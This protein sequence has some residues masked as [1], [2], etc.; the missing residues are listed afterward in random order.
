[1]Y[2][3]FTYL[4]ILEKEGK[5]MIPKII[6]YC[7]FGKNQH[8]LQMQKCRESWKKYLPDYKIIEWNEE[9]FSIPDAN[10]YVREAYERKKYAFVSDYV[11]IKALID[12]GGIYLD[13]DYELCGDIKGLLKRGELITGFESD[14]SLLTAIIMAEPSHPFLKKFIDTYED[15]KFIL[16]NGEM[17]LTPINV[18]FSELAQLYGIDLSRNCQQIGK[19]GFYV[20]PKEVLCGFDVENW[21]ESVSENT[22]GVHHMGNT[23]ASPKMKR[24]IQRIKFWQKVLGYRKYDRI[25]MIWRKRKCD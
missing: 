19:N 2:H 4:E 1:M 10:C 12:F 6:H 18:G 23:W 25:R 3:L 16:P 7:W 15:R 17:D 21:H 8:S 11:R 24:H 5:N 20:Y 14:K 9:N 13:T 22:L